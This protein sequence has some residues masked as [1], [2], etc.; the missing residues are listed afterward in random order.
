MFFWYGTLCASMGLSKGAFC[1]LCAK[2]VRE[3][4]QPT[5][6]CLV[7]MTISL[8]V[9]LYEVFA[10]LAL[11]CVAFAC[12]FVHVTLK[13]YPI[14]CYGNTFGYPIWGPPL[15]SCPHCHPLLGSPPLVS[16][17]HQR[18]SGATSRHRGDRI[19]HLRRCH[20]HSRHGPPQSRPLVPPGSTAE[21][22]FAVGIAAIDTF[23]CILPNFSSDGRKCISPTD[24]GSILF[25]VALWW[26]RCLVHGTHECSNSDPIAPQLLA[27][28]FNF[29]ISTGGSSV[30]VV[31][32]G[33]G[34][35]S[36]HV[37]FAKESQFLENVPT[38]LA[39]CPQPPPPCA[40]RCF[41]AVQF[42]S[43]PKI[44]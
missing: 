44:P 37:L 6:Q 17:H 9:H 30:Q 42:S 10:C 27:L 12:V 20:N 24:V 40:M 43:T 28:V 39:C 32:V 1:A 26:S 38:I 2:F 31:S 18:L 8:V 41:V 19:H 34:A 21:I 36:K 23:F 29:Q 33:F 15:L 25:F 13:G 5:Y 35:T 16:S 22:T 7:P 3:C 11:I 4:T 14:R